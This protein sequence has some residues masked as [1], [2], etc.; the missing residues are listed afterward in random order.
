MSLA[1]AIASRNALLTTIGKSALNIKYP[2]EFELYVIALELTDENFNTLKYFVFPINPSSLEETIPNLT[3]VKKTLAGVTVLKSPTFVPTD[4]TLSGSFG[5]SFKILLGSSYEDLISSFRIENIGRFGQSENIVSS[6]SV[7]KGLKQI[8]D[9][10]IKTGYGCIKILEEIV[11]ES[12]S[13]GSDGK[14]RKLIFHNPALGNSYL[15]TAGAMRIFQNEQT[16]MIWNYSLPLKSIAPLESL[17][18]QKKLE[19]IAV[20]L[21]V[22]SFIQQRVNGLLNKTSRLLGNTIDTIPSR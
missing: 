19:S 18:N 17:F 7:G 16:N 11:K 5:R 10:R 21:N 14:L 22:T 20:Q 13:I 15:V 4:I 2:K 8:F 3:N 1:S 12:T 6:N 9:E